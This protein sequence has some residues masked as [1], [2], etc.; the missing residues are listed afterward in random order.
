[1]FIDIKYTDITSLP[2]SIYLKSVWQVT[3]Q[4]LWQEES[5]DASKTG[6][7]AHDDQGQD[8][9]DCSLTSSIMV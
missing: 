2:H 5:S 4:S 7:C 3:P 8:S 1:M 6:E 9:V